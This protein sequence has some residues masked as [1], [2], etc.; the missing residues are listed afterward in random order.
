M[1][2][3]QQLCATRKWTTTLGGYVMDIPD[4]GFAMVNDMNQEMLN[5]KAA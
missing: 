2:D 3:V 1:K 5:L 4:T